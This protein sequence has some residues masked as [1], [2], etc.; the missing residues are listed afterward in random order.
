MF[1]F[2]LYHSKKNFYLK[3]LVGIQIVF[4][5]LLLIDIMIENKIFLRECLVFSTFGIYFFVLHIIKN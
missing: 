1:L 3:F 5:I 4:I 2:M